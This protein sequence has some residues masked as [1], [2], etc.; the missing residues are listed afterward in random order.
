[1]WRPRWAPHSFQAAEAVAARLTA[2]HARHLA[3]CWTPLG[4]T[5]GFC[6]QPQAA[7]LGKLESALQVHVST[8]SLPNLCS[9]Q[10]QLLA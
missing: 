3:G 4:W 5:L 7:A 2:G 6:L 9:P 1:M 8:S 10:F